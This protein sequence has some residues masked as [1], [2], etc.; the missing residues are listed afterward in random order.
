MPIRRIVLNLGQICLKP[1][2]FCYSYQTDFWSESRQI[3]VKIKIVHAVRAR[4]KAL[5]LFHQTTAKHTCS[6]RL[7]YK[8][9]KCV[10][11]IGSIVCTFQKGN[12]VVFLDLLSE[13]WL[14]LS[15]CEISRVRTKE[16]DFTLS[17]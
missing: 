13:I 15:G 2:T 1:P 6:F 3:F 4:E 8:T 9:L 11:N 17:I 5:I 16:E 12:Y 10:C 14:K 7:P